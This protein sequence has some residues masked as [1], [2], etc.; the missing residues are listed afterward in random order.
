MK[1][2]FAH[3]DHRIAPVFDTARQ[4][5][6]IETDS[7]QIISEKPETLSEELGVRK[8]LRLVELGI[9]TLVCGAISKP[10]QGLV[11]AYGIQV[12]PFVAGDLREV[13][14]AWLG[15]NLMREEFVMPGCR[16]QGRQRFRGMHE[17]YQEVNTMQGRGRGTGAG[18]RGGGQGQGQ[19]GQ[20][21]GS[22]GGGRGAGAA[23]YCVCPQCGQ[24]EPHQRGVPCFERQCPKCGIA[25]IRQ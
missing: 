9:N 25:M 24:T 18:G 15:G 6:V 20:R 21:P 8:V 7:G 10:M 14:Q 1:T 22:G 3:W 23:G 5:H 13:I 17:T 4:V 12:I 19:G 2:A 16:G 11:T